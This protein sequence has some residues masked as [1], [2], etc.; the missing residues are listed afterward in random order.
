VPKNVLQFA[1]VPNSHSLLEFKKYPSLHLV[2]PILTPKKIPV[3]SQLLREDVIHFPE[4][5]RR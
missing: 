3:S 5:L 1:T 2:H 4:L